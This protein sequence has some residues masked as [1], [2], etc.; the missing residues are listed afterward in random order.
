[1]RYILN[2][3]R[4][5]V[6]SCTLKRGSRK[7]YLLAFVSL[8][9]LTRNVPIFPIR[10][11]KYSFV[12]I[13]FQ[14]CSRDDFYA[15]YEICTGFV[16][17]VTIR[18]TARRKFVYINLIMGRLQES[19]SWPSDTRYCFFTWKIL[20]LS[21]VVNIRWVNICRSL[22]SCCFFLFGLYCAVHVKRMA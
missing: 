9:F 6:R 21:I 4:K 14:R 7:C 15:K 5:R 16:E 13:S 3:P 19:T 1:M 11:E 12:V 10:E 17:Q 20:T 8:L 22:Q 18:D 2:A